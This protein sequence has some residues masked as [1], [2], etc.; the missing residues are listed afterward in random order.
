MI[1][2]DAY[3]RHRQRLPFQQRSPLRRGDFPIQFHHPVF[4][5]EPGKALNLSGCEQGL[6]TELKLLGHFLFC[7]QVAADLLHSR[8]RQDQFRQAFFAPGG[9]DRAKQGDGPLLHFCGEPLAASN[10]ANF[11]LQALVGLSGQ[12]RIC[13]LEGARHLAPEAPSQGTQPAK[14]V[15]FRKRWSF[16][17]RG[18]R[19][20]CG[21]GSG[22]QDG[23]H[24]APSFSV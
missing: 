11:V 13:P 17:L 5:E 18:S 16:C 8:Q 22:G 10:L 9:V 19:G 4:D 23:H 1:E 6:E 20:D 15:G 12:L 21:H 24:C 14:V 3:P 7:Q 2:H